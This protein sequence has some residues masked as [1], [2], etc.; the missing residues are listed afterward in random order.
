MMRKRIAAALAAAA[1][2]PVCALGET[3][4]GGEVT[5]DFAQVIAAPYGGIVGQVAV[6][7]GDSVKIGDPIAVIETNKTYAMT[8][9]TVSGVFASEGDSAEGIK[10]RYGALVY[11]E[12]INRYT[13]TC[14][15]EKAY[16]SSENRYIHIGETV[17]L[18]CTKDGSHQGRGI[19][20]A[21]DKEDES[22]F[23]V[24][25][26]GGEFY[27]GESVGVFRDA[28]YAA[29]S[30]IGRGEVGRTAPVAVTGEGS[31]LRMHVRAGDRV[32]R[33]ELLFETVSGTL[34]GLY[35]PDKQVVS[36][37]AGVIASVDAGNGTSVEK[38]AKIATIYPE[39][40]MQVRME[41]S[42]ADLP[43]VRVGGKASIEFNWD[44]DS[45]KR[46]EGTIASISYLSEKAEEGA[47]SQA[48]NYVA[49]IDFEPDETVRIGMTV[50]V[51]V[52]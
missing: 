2:L 13:L 31:V 39:E 30:R 44:A 20:T 24:E 52:Q 41:I 49:Y 3:V 36:D 10:E 42:E 21:V 28:A 7:A 33:G 15:T 6:R 22:K 43:D 8:D 12:P 35:A 46:Y 47:A 1:C 32:E 50:V 16:N 38:G 4:F 27:M 14:S 29:E 45:G 48:A 17:Y 51:Y 19:V 34:D 40:R 11:I 23:T 5:A 25:V 18:S 37:T 26:T 9:G